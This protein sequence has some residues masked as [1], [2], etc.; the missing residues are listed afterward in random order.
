[1][2]FS[3]D[4][5]VAADDAEAADGNLRGGCGNFG[6]VTSFR[7][8]AHPVSSVLGRVILCARDQA[9]SE[10]RFYRDFMDTA[11]EE[12]TVYA[13]LIST[14]D[15]TPAA[16]LMACYCGDPTEGERGMK[17]LRTIVTPIFEA[18]QVMPF[19]VMQKLVD[20]SNPDGVHNYWRSTFLRELND[21]VI[22]L[23]IEHGDK[24]GSP[25]SDVLVQIFNGAARRIDN[26]ATAFAHWNAGFHI[27][28]ETKWTD[29]AQSPKHMAWTHAFSD[30]LEPYSIQSRLMN[31]LGDEGTD[32]PRA[33]LWQQLRASG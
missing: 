23:V 5:A 4:K 13:G 10:L 31:F 2:T 22:D 16:A 27:G 20:E 19:P 30:A 7:F 24:A 3:A 11:P 18:I 1:M 25:L 29:P 33:G 8:Q 14:P 12:L 26:A 9:A 6:V 21:E 17:P 32:A 28:I 15:G